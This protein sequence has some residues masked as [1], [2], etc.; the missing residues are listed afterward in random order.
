MIADA[1]LSAIQ[2][3]Y[4][5]CN[6]FIASHAFFIFSILI[7]ISESKIFEADDYYAICC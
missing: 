3:L 1:L 4:S 5:A 6:V 2:T 7:F